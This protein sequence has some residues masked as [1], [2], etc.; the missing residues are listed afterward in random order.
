N[1]RVI[2]TYREVFPD[3]VIGLSSHDNGIAM[4]LIGYML[5]ARV[6]EKHFTLNRA[7]KGTD[8]VFSL[9]PDGMRRM[10]RDLRRVD[11]AL[12]NGIKRMY[13]NEKVPLMKMGKK[14]VAARA[15]PVGHR[16]TTEDVAIKSPAD[17]LPP[18][19]LTNVIGKVTK[20]ALAED[21]NILFEDLATK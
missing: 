12:G 15:L 17:G 8:H 1:L 16:I 19:E 7:M 10:V 20:K 13:E 6:I 3:I 18:Y 5:G 11:V 9:A 14:L 4:S 2:D 21:D